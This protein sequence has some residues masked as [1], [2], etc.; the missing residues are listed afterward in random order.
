[1]RSQSMQLT[2]FKDGKHLNGT[3][4]VF[5]GARGGDT[6]EAKFEKAEPAQ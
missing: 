3:I 5:A 4:Y 2:L 1:M 6:R